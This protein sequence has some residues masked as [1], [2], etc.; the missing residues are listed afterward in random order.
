MIIKRLFRYQNLGIFLFLF[1][2]LMLILYLFTNGFTEQEMI[3]YIILV[4]LF[5]IVL[6]L[7]PV[8]E[9]FM[10]LMIGAK[11]IKRKDMKLKIVPLLE[12]VYNRAY[13]MD[14]LM[15]N[16]IKLKIIYSNNANAYAIGKRTIVITSGLLKLSDKCILGILAHEIGHLVH[17]DSQ[18]QLLVSG[19]NVFI[20]A[21]LFL[22][23][24]ITIL[25]TVILSSAA[26]KSD[27][28]VVA[29]IITLVGAI[30]T[31]LITLW[32]KVCILFLKS[33]MRANEYY[34]DEFACKLGFGANLA[35]A[36]EVIE[37]DDTDNTFFKIINS[38]HPNYNDRVARLQALGADYMRVF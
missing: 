8:G 24:L 17:R 25:V 36:L 26:F 34:A 2:N 29:V 15:V 30:F 31:F 18:V 14:S 5:F 16:S 21:T 13:Q 38:T 1:L 35:Y 32:S 6:S 23:K 37:N 28:K 22:V 4:Y 27:N 11:E 33:S 20:S 10:C 7:S 12:V 9:W 3:L 19:S